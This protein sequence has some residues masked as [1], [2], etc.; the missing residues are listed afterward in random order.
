MTDW[1]KDTWNPLR[2]RTLRR[3]II[4]ALAGL[5]LLSAAPGL[6]QDVASY[7]NK[8]VRLIVPWPVGGATDVMARIVADKLST[9]LGQP[10]VVEN[11]PG[12]TGYIGTQQVIQA[13]P[14][15]Y[16]LLAMA[17]S[18]HSFTPSV[19]RTMPFDPVTGITP[20][21][22]F[23]TFPSVLAVST[24]SPFKSVGDLIAAAKAAPGKLTFGS[25]GTG[26]AAHLIPELLA[27]STGVQFLHVPYKGAAPALTDL[28]GGQITFVIDSIPSPLPQIRN[29]RL[30][31]L[32][33][34]SA[35][36]SAALPDVPTIAETMPGFEA[37]I[38][39]GIGGPP[40][41]PAAIANKIAG[42]IGEIARDP[43][44]IAQVLA[45]GANAASSS[46]PDAFKTFM[47][48][49]RNLW[50]KV[51]TVAKIPKTDQ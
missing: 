3:T 24:D 40:G 10:F 9:K 35:Q 39:L 45:L 43:A 34:T 11:K 30:K 37:S 14:D 19:A 7:P 44:Y 13:A 25:S 15:G 42:A 28:M 31:A 5:S 49:Q 46:S 16:T 23:V 36:R 2:G 29:G 41:L 48:A 1:I 26:S 17:A 33:V 8:P 18:L 20:I 6:A 12:A 50:E 32:A 21:S 51:V 47:M 27:T 22:V 38:W 4:A